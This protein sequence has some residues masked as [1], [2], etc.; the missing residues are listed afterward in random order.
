MTD[1]TPE[2]LDVMWFTSSR[3]LVGIV[4]VQV[5]PTE[6]KFYIS[7]ADGFNEVIDANLIMS[8]GA[9]FPQEAGYALF[10]IIGELV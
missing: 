4:A 9:V 10:G 8:H 6:I 5:E 2:L 3:G 1:S 7:P